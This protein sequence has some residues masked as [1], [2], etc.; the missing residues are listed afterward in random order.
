MCAADVGQHFSSDG[1]HCMPFNS[2]GGVLPDGNM[3]LRYIAISEG[4][5]PRRALRATCITGELARCSVPSAPGGVIAA[6]TMPVPVPVPCWLSTP[7][8]SSSPAEQY[9]AQES[10]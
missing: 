2:M 4:S 1:R 10:S 9:R 5:R 8:S 6:S 3:S 7:S